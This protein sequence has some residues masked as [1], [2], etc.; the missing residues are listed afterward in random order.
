[1]LES[2]SYGIVLL[3]LASMVRSILQPEAMHIFM[4]AFVLASPVLLGL[5]I[6][7]ERM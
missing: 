7:H 1:M 4:L 3:F 5:I 6:W 2:V